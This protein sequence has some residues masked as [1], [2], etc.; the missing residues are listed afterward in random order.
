M[1]FSAINFCTNPHDNASSA[2]ILS[3]VNI[4]CFAIP[5]PITSNSLFI[6]EKG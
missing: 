5:G 3:A 1:S 2:E 4:K 6:E